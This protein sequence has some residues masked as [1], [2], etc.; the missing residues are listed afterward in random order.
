MLRDRRDVAS[1]GATLREAAQRIDR[2]TTRA[3][4]AAEDAV[5]LW[6]SLLD[7]T[8]S[9]IERFESDNRRILIA[10]RNHPAVRRRRALSERERAIVS[11]LAAGHSVKVC[12]YELGLAQS[13]T[14]ELANSA[15]RK[16]G[17]PSRGALVELYAAITSSEPREGTVATFR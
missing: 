14:S 10:Q 9:L 11:L 6:H 16:L 4:V 3:C 13:T 8:W 1:N 12:A 15:M 5:W 17:V 2:T 7:G